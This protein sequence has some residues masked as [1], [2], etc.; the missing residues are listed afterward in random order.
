M[1]DEL[2]I[3]AKKGV[4]KRPPSRRRVRMRDRKRSI[5]VSDGRERR[6]WNGDRRIRHRLEGDVP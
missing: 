6:P 5:R 4:Q 3:L 1:R 2:S